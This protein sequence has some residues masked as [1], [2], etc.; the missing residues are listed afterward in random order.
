[1]L[2]VEVRLL[3]LQKTALPCAGADKVANA[4]AWLT[5]LTQLADAAPLNPFKQLCIEEAAAGM[6]WNSSRYILRAQEPAQAPQVHVNSPCKICAD[7]RSCPW[8]SSWQCAR[9]CL[10]GIAGS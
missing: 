4:L 3:M 6:D 2:C 7:G 9:D 10:K 8:R 5:V 1:M